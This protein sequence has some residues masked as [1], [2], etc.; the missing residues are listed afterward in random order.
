MVV[1]Q[2]GVGTAVMVGT[3]LMDHTALVTEAL[4]P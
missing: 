1:A 3:F 4:V 2:D